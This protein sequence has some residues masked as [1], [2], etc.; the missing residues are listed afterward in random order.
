MIAR[1][2]GREETEPD[3]RSLCLLIFLFFFCLYVLTFK[4]ICTGDN[5]LHY[6]LVVNA[7]TTGQLSLPDDQYD[8]DKQRYLKPYISEGLDGRLYLTLPPGLALASIPGGALGMAIESLVKAPQASDETLA[9]RNLAEVRAKPSAFFAGLINPLVSA[10][11]IAL[12]FWMVSRI[13]DSVEW[14]AFLSLMLGLSTIIWPYSTT[15]WTQPLATVAVFGSFVL[16]ARGMEADRLL[17]G[18]LSGLLAGFGFLTRYETLFLRPVVGPVHFLGLVPVDSET[19]PVPARVSRAHSRRDSVV[20]GMEP[21]SLRVGPRRWCVPS[22]SRVVSGRPQ[23]EL[24]R[25]PDQP[26]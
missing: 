9:R 5:L 22:E 17:L 21:L 6:D 10:L 2:R 16:L 20:D 4:G 23:A 24:A 11:L 14:A 7:V 8:L 1:F 3:N 25:Q 18:A 12:F 15:Y 26:R 19:G 13:A